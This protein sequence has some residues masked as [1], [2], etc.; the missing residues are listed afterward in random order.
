MLF[1][2]V[3][4][5]Y[6]RQEVPTST[7]ALRTSIHRIDAP[8]AGW[9]FRSLITR[10]SSSILSVSQAL[11]CGDSQDASAGLSVRNPRQDRPSRTAGS[12][13]MTK[14]HC[15]PCRPN[16][17]S[18]RSNG[19]EIKGP[20]AAA[21]TPHAT[22]SAV[23]RARYAEGNQRKAKKI[24]PGK[25]PASAAP[26]ANLAM[27]RPPPSRTAAVIAETIPQVISSTANQMRAPS[28]D[29]TRLLGTENNT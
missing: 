14:S 25:R 29:R 8:R 16:T 27:I 13:S 28:L 21:A 6:P 4:S 9:S 15:Q 23:K 3:G 10:R 1:K 5:Q 2:T 17:F 20:I 11:S 18:N 12:P 26:S 7:L 19:T 22:N 24:T